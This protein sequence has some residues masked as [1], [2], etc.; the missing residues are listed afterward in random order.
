ME[1]LDIFSAVQDLL[2]KATDVPKAIV[3]R[4]ST[5]EDLGINSLIITEVLSDMQQ[6]FV[7]E[8]PSEV[9][10]ALSDVQVLCGYQNSKY[11]GPTAESPQSM[12]DLSSSQEDVDTL[13]T[14]RP[15]NNSPVDSLVSRS[16]RL[17]A[18][19]LETTIIMAHETCLADQDMDSL[20]GVNSLNNIEKTLDT[21]VQMEQ[22]SV[23]ST[24]RDL[25][26]SVLPERQTQKAH[27]EAENPENAQQIQ[28]VEQNRPETGTKPATLTNTQHACEAVRYDY[29]DYTIKTGFSTFW[30]QCFPAQA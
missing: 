9:F 13:A 30:S 21:R 6:A 10:M 1:S 3:K 15:Y 2:S 22:I 18:E 12:T 27:P 28:H 24:F 14:D 20:I 8:I 7:I 26:N 23:K 25:C 19:H 5:L 4:E 11:G 16:A 17:M 29:K